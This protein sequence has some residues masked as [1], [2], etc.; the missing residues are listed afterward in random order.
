MLLILSRSV[1]IALLLWQSTDLTSKAN[2]G[3]ISILH[4]SP[5]SIREADEQYISEPVGISTWVGLYKIDEGFAWRAT[6]VRIGWARVEGP[7]GDAPAG[8]WTGKHVAAPDEKTKPI[9]LAQGLD[10]LD[11]VRVTP[12][13]F[14]PTYRQGLDM[15]LPMQF[16]FAG[17]SYAFTRSTKAKGKS[18][19]FAL[20]LNQGGRRQVLDTEEEPQAC[21][22]VLWAGDLDGDGKLDLLL[23]S[24]CIDSTTRLMLSSRAAQGKFLATVA[25]REFGSVE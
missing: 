1:A 17:L 20:V 10:G 18:E 14:P 21:W 7:D 5:G 25:K 2:A 22:Q 13:V 24:G 15:M 16:K 23:S 8:P 12:A 9:I 11:S 19:S 6:K 4:V 3:K